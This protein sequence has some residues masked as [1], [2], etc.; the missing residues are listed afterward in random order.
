M[1]YNNT[2]INQP[3]ITII[4]VTYNAADHLKSCLHSVRN[5]IYKDFELIIVDGASSD[6]TLE[7]IRNNQDLITKWKS[8]PDRGIYDAMNK[9][10]GMAK[11]KWLYF[12]GADDMLLD[13]FS[14]IALKL[15]NEKTLYYGHCILNGKITG[16]SYSKYKISKIN[17]CHHGI[18]YPSSIFQKYSYKTEYVISA[19]HLLNIQCWGD[20]NLKKKY[21]H[22]P[23][24]R[25]QSGGFS[26]KNKDEL[27]RRDKLEYIKKYLGWLVYIRYLIRIKKEKI[28]GNKDF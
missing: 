28:R 22:I 8:E 4:I 6:K 25:F 15:T 14:E 21:Y 19:D 9:G 24:A 26:F 12:L 5:Q 23:V 7:I 11:G 20:S 27:F 13:G 3:K 10:V 17:V 18:F 1:T 16:K 2:V